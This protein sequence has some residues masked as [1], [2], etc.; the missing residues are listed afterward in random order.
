M[1]SRNFELTHDVG[2]LSNALAGSGCTQEVF[3]IPTRVFAN[4][5]EFRFDWAP[6]LGIL[7]AFKVVSVRVVVGF[8]SQQ[9]VQS[10]FCKGDTLVHGIEIVGI[11]G[12][13]Q[14]G[15]QVK[16]L[17]KG[18]GFALILENFSGLVLKV[19]GFTAKRGNLVVV[20]YYTV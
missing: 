19:I 18:K 5:I 6:F 9:I 20:V 13:N 12:G 3:V 15:N 1:T 10:E 8:E 11:H 2:N 17:G 4:L 14:C 7:K 16:A